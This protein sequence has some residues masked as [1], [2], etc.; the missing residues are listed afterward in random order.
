MKP[1]RFG[2][3]YDVLRRMPIVLIMSFMLM[4]PN[5]DIA[6][7]VQGKM[8]LDLLDKIIRKH[9][10]KVERNEGFW[11]FELSGVR[12]LCVTDTEHDRMRLIAPIIAVSEIRDSQM[13]DMLI[14]NFHTALDGRYAISGDVVFAA[15]IHPLSSLS[16][17]ELEAAL[18]QVASLAKTFG[19][20][21]SVGTL[22]FGGPQEAEEGSEI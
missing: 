5:L 4:V 17:E 6:R 13:K 22:V 19:T 2:A 1:G 15:F 10:G 9:S 12:L 16:L 21:Y 20:T 8:D 14:A 7:A 18:G 3:S 11:E